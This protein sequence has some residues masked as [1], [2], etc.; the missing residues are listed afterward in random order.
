MAAM[1]VCR[2]RPVR[3]RTD[4]LQSQSP[5][6]IFAAGHANPRPMSHDAAATLMK[7]AAYAS[8]GVA[9][10]LTAIKAAAYLYSN[11]VAMLASMADSGLDLL[12]SAGNLFAIRQ[13][14]TPADREHRFGHGKA[15]PL[16]GLAQ[17]A[18]IIA[19]ALFLSVQSLGRL[20]EPAPVE[21]S[22]AALAVMAVSIAATLMLLAYQR[23]VIA[24][25]RST[26]IRAD[27]AHYVGDLA[28]NLAVVAAV[29][30]SE[31]L[32]WLRADP[33]LA[34]GVAAI[35]L[36]SAYGV[37]RD[38]LDQLM[39]RE[40]PDQD[41][42]RIAAIVRANPAVRN[43]HELK[44]RMAGRSTFIQVHVEMDPQM[45]LAESH[46]VSDAVERAIMAAYPGAEVI[47]HQDPEGL[48]S[49]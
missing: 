42:A 10:L 43:L 47:I 41:R 31:F 40:L 2:A 27:R 49:A 23:H 36:A 25:S 19:S 26:A 3:K 9:L 28:A 32:G 37:G 1:T 22:G 17:C 48:E 21:H 33:L 6:G 39:D 34:L 5:A 20:I 4:A 29:L 38:S 11:S 44:T 14:L 8:I 15:E 46:A 13:A 24:A 45:R 16:A 18:F 12:A 30:L 7:R 35:M